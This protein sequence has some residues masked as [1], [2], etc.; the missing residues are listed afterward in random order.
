MSLRAIT[1]I[2]LVFISVNTNAQLF[3]DIPSATTIQNSI[4]TFEK[5][6]LS[7]INY[8]FKQP[9]G[10]TLKINTQKYFSLP[11]IARAYHQVDGEMIGKKILSSEFKPYGK[12]G[13]N[14]VAIPYL[15]EREGDW[16]F[17]LTYLVPLAFLSKDKNYLPPKAYE[18]LIFQLL[19]T[20]GDK[21]YKK[22]RLGICGKITDTENHILMTE[23]ARYLTNDLRADFY[24][25]R[26]KP[27]PR[28]IDNDL[29]GFHQWWVDHLKKIKEEHFDE[30]NSRP[31]QGYALMPITNLAGFSKNLEVKAAAQ[32]ILDHLT[33]IYLTQSAGMIRNVPFRRQIVYETKDDLIV[34]DGEVARHAYLTGITDFYTKIDN[35]P[36]VKY[37]KNFMLI[38]AVADFKINERILHKFFS[39]DWLPKFTKYNHQTPEI[40][41]NSKSFTLSAGGRHVNRLDGGTKQNDGWARTTTLL[42]RQ[43]PKIKISD[44]FRFKGHKFRLSRKNTC[45]YKNFACG[46]N[47][48][49]PK[50]LPPKC[51]FSFGGFKFYDLSSS[52]CG[53]TANVLVAELV[54]PCQ[55]AKC[56]FKADNYGL[57]EV[58]ESSELSFNSFISQ[59]LTNNLHLDLQMTRP[60]TYKTTLGEEINFIPGKAGKKSL[61]IIN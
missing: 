20:A 40:Y 42:L 9:V 21:H 53:K 28:E 24:R 30:Y 13:T 59:V 5:R 19:N 15:C 31:Y 37:G 14:F 50:K 12:V 41:Y 39:T 27:V 1:Y 38:T 56:W 54:K 10:D 58:R 25:Q 7:V 60:N 43:A 48:A 4:D 52:E 22:F 17:A 34:G 46:I 57:L 61:E 47:Y 16:D 26:N 49:R 18:K 51:A 11:A 44:H 6:K 3:K 29:N 8:F 2:F 32:D 35:I 23:S 33:E 45:V 55:G 36:Y